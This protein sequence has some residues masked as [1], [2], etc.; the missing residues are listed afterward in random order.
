MYGISAGDQMPDPP[1]FLHASMVATS[2]SSE[3]ALHGSSP[4]ITDA[5]SIPQKL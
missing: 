4:F 1:A 3:Q 5:A 2:K